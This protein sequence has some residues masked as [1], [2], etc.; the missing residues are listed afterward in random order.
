MILIGRHLTAEGYRSYFNSQSVLFTGMAEKPNGR[1][2]M[3]H[4]NRL[5]SASDNAN[6][7]RLLELIRRHKETVALACEAR[8][9]G[10]QRKLDAKVDRLERAIARSRRNVGSRPG[11]DAVRQ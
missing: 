1:I 2:D 4:T 10:S 5:A 9:K 7:R 8:D 11:E 3:P 6:E